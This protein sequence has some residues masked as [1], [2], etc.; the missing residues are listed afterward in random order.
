MT[1]IE[2]AVTAAATALAEG[3]AAAAAA[4]SSM[5]A[6]TAAAAGSGTAAAAAAGA[7][8]LWGAGATGAAAAGGTAAAA[9]GGMTAAEMAMLGLSAA[10]VGATLLTPTPKMETPILN[11]ANVM[12]TEDSEAI[13]KTRQRSM[14]AQQQRQGRASTMLSDSY[15]KLGG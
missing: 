14:V 9:A 5:F 7:S 13:M 6:G 2:V 15:D 8:T 12:P 4:A 1:G 10:S 11:E 3:A